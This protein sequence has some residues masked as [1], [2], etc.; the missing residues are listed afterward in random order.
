M[1]TVS[2][3]SSQTLVN[4]QENIAHLPNTGDIYE[5][6]VGRGNAIGGRGNINFIYNYASSVAQS[7]ITLEDGRFRLASLKHATD[8][9]N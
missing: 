5:S 6:I 4:E 2:R 7:A 1:S 3:R 9:A 8:T